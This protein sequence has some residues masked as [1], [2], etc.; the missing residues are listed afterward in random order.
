MK[1]IDLSSWPR[2]S[3]F[4]LFREHKMPHFTVTAEVDIA[5]MLSHIKPQGSSIFVATMFCLMRSVNAVR[6]LRMR[7][8][9][10]TVVE[11]PFTD[12]GVTVPIE[13]DRFNFCYIEYSED[14]K[15]FEAKAAR[16]IREATSQTDL[17]NED[18]EHDNLT[19]M[20]CL[21]WMSATSIQ[22]PALCQNDCVPRVGWS[23]FI[24]R[25][26][27]TMQPVHIMA[28]HAL[29]DG[30]HVGRFFQHL[31]ALLADVPGTFSL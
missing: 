29:V 31:E 24:K 13:G 2:K 28:H 8:D 9:G 27:R 26:G 23:K 3:H 19:Y 20:T 15:T 10:D 5:D 12:T 17:V 30:L 21:P 14:W 6:E 22:F 25:E 4:L 1:T 16:A 7:F 18:S 11:H